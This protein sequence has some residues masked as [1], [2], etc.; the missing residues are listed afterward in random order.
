MRVV[1]DVNVFVSALIAPRGTAG[2]L[3]RVLIRDG[4]TVFLVSPDTKAEL[5]RVLEYP[6]I[7]KLLKFSADEIER[8]LCSV[9]M[10]SEEFDERSSVDGLECRDADDIKFLALAV[11]GR[12]DYLVSGDKDLLVLGS[13]ECIPIVTPAQLL[14]R[15]IG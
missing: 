2:S 5:K 3:L 8:F 6:K 15:M 10:L 1:V 13:V 7:S 14:E 11:L 9:E 4:R 12:A